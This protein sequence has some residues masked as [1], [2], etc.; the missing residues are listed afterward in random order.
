MQLSLEDNIKRLADEKKVIAE[1]QDHFSKLA[2]T[3]H[4]RLE[5]TS[6]QLK[7][8][9]H[10]SHSNHQELLDDMMRIHNMAQII[11][12]K[13]GKETITKIFKLKF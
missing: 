10:E 4:S 3:V 12:Q 11:F 13:I 2:Q 9:S 5:K 8:Q 7:T 6:E 1:A